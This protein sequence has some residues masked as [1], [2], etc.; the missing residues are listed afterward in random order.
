[1]RHSRQ[2]EVT[3][4]MEAV[5]PCEQVTH[6]RPGA[7]SRHAQGSAHQLQR[8]H[9][10]LLR[11]LQLASYKQRVALRLEWGGQTQRAGENRTCAG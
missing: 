1:M 11:R 8:R 10:L 3:G 6:V 9:I 2:V 7:E 5:G 4:G